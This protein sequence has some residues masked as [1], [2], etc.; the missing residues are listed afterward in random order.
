MD[1]QQ[2]DKG[3]T[4]DKNGQIQNKVR[5]KKFVYDHDEEIE[6]SWR[7]M[8]SEIWISETF[9]KKSKKIWPSVDDEL[10]EEGEDL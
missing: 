9:N 1:K 5:F 6:I 7:N 3:L 8:P 10:T 2:R 4:F